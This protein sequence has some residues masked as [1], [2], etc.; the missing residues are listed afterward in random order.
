MSTESVPL[1]Q[2]HQQRDRTLLH[3]PVHGENSD[4]EEDGSAPAQPEEFDPII[5][6]VLANP[7]HPI[8]R[9]AAL[10]F[11]SAVLRGDTDAAAVDR[12]VWKRVGIVVGYVGQTDEDLLT[13]GLAKDVSKDLREL[14]R[15]LLGVMV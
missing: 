13:R 3:G 11:L 6:P 15:E 4:I 9:R 7:K 8:L 10:H 2:P 5:S 12:D 14:M 1:K